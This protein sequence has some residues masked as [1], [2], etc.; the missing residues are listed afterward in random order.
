MA[1]QDWTPST[2]MQEHL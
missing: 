2:V 1:K